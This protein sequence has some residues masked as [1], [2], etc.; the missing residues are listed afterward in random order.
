MQ[1]S[2]IKLYFHHVRSA[3]V[4][5]STVLVFLKCNT[6]QECARQ[7]FARHVFAR[8]AFARQQQTLEELYLYSFPCL[9]PKDSVLAELLVQRSCTCLNAQHWSTLPNLFLGRV[10]GC[11]RTF[12]PGPLIHL[13]Q[14]KK[15]FKLMIYKHSCHFARGRAEGGSGF[16]TQIL[17]AFLAFLFHVRKL[18]THQPEK[19]IFF[20][21]RKA[22]YFNW[23]LVSWEGQT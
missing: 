12:L 16:C 22:L 19:K 14:K 13:F 20:H 4:H 9:F 3:A 5:V 11:L 23:I 1:R 21:I 6:C 17:Q 18:F 15:S 2:R 10:T 8:Q 7:D